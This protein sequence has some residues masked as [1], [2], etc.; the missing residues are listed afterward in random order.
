MSNART[1]DGDRVDRPTRILYV[2]VWIEHR[3][4]RYSIDLDDANEDTRAYVGIIIGTCRADR[5]TRAVRYASS[6]D[7]SEAALLDRIARRD[8]TDTCPFTAIVAAYET[9]RARSDELDSRIAELSAANVEIGKLR[10]ELGS[11]YA[12]C[13]QAAASLRASSEAS[14]VLSSR[15]VSAT[16]DTSL[17]RTELAECRALNARLNAQ[18]NAE[19]HT[20]LIARE[21]LEARLAVRKFRRMSWVRRNELYL[22]ASAGQ[23]GGGGSPCAAAPR[24]C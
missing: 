22:S 19:R 1:D 21:E 4:L 10:A 13:Q 7:A 8:A 20:V 23:G 15:L 2:L 3:L 16:A 14:H 6:M 5:V 12:A 18:L 9:A 24:A 11:A 17:L